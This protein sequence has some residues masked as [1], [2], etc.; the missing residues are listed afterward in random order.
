MERAAE[1]AAAGLALVE[2]L[3][4]DPTSFQVKHED[5]DVWVLDK[6]AG[7]ATESVATRPSLAALLARRSP[8]ERVWVVQRLDEATSGLLVMAKNPVANRALSRAAAEHR[9][10]RVYTAVV[11]GAFPDDLDVLDAPLRGRRARTRVTV[12]DR[13]GHLA[14]RL[15]CRLETGRTHQI[16]LHCARAGHPLLGDPRHGQRTAWD[17]PRMAL[18]A[19]QLGFR[20]P[21]T[22][23]RLSFGSP[24]PAELEVWLAALATIVRQASAPDHPR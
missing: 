3:P 19:A 4:G 1:R 21:R 23:R 12:V 15:E 13:F 24:L 8:A 9:F 10:D 14:T 7:L 6:P 11:R 5:G 20:H 17:P 18:H 16:R 22:D 2:P